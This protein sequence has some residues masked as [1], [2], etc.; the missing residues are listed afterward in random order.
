M[1]NDWSSYL[2]GSSPKYNFSYRDETP[3][4]LPVPTA[5]PMP[6]SVPLPSPQPQSMNKKKNKPE[7]PTIKGGARRKS[8]RRYR[9]RRIITRR[10][11]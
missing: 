7:I 5:K 11:N 9:Q 1:R 3:V 4:P 6:L 10:R 8:V 2:N